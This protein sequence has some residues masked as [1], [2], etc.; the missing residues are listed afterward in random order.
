MTN[1]L[2]WYQLLNV[3]GL[4]PKSLLLLYR[5]VKENSIQVAEIFSMDQGHFYKIFSEFGKGKFSRVKYENFRDMD[6]K[7]IFDSYQQLKEKGITILPLNDTRY[8][9]NI[10]K[11]LKATSPPVLFCKGHL[12]LL[13]TKNVSIVGARSADE[14]TL[15]L[16]SRLAGALAKAGYNVVSGY[17][18]GVDTNAHLGA[19]DANGT[20]TVVLSL[21]MNHLSV[22]RDFKDHKWEQGTL[23]VSQ[24]LPHEKWS[25][26][27]AMT[28]NKIVCGLSDAVV[29]M[30]AGP[31]RDE[32]GRMSGTFDAGKGALAMGV[33]VFVLS[34][35]RIHNPPA[36][37]SE[38][39][40][41][42]GIEFSR[43]EEILNFLQ[44]DT[45][46]TPLPPTIQ[47]SMFE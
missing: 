43:E 25:A 36:G 26:K 34:P 12:P 30:A 46:P 6:E 42:G 21:G 15:H 20:T 13:I 19:L 45:T 5:A 40:K 31:E 33:P 16:T 1:E 3:K 41:L 27:N 23:F 11:R 32:K 29:V 18:K 47:L 4:G 24:F 38:L 10:K 17:A 8:P 7:H 14:P 39:I 35:S 2:A 28:R 22:K 37:N 9:Q 44:N